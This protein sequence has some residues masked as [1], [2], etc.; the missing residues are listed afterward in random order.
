MNP[1]A[2]ACPRT[3]RL[4]RWRL[5]LPRWL[6]RRTACSCSLAGEFAVYGDGTPESPY[7]V[8]PLLPGTER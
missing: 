8:A 5:T 6:S 3:V 4:W 7:T 1:R 2:H